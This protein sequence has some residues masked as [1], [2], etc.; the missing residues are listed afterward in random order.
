MYADMYGFKNNFCSRINLFPLV[1]LK[2]PHILYECKEVLF[3]GCCYFGLSC[4][5][6]FILE[7]QIYREKKRL[8]ERSALPLVHSPVGL[9]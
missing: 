9:S 7:T 4:L 5:F 2:H 6:L 3:I 8:R 1:F